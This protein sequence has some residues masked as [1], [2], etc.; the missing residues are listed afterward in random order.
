[1]SNNLVKTWGS[2]VDSLWQDC[3]YL[4]TFCTY[5]VVQITAMCKTYSP[6]SRVTRGFYNGFSTPNNQN[7]SLFYGSLYTLSTAPITTATNLYINSY[8]YRKGEV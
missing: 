6:Y 4:Y 5:N 3:V 8:C 1:M 2:A 7:F